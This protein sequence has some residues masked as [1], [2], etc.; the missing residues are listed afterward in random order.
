LNFILI[1]IPV[2]EVLS[3]DKDCCGC[4][5]LNKILL[6]KGLQS[7]IWYSIRICWK[8]VDYVKVGTPEF[9]FVKP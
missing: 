5:D 6:A 7:G 4:L 1:K 2:Y 8:G 9:T 3:G